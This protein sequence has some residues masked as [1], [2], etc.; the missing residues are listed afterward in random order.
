MKNRVETLIDVQQ[1]AML[2]SQSYSESLSNTPP[3]YYVIM[4]RD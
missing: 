2:D 3:E 4:Y 1:P